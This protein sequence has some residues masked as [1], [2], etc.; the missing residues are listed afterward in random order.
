MTGP[1]PEPPAGTAVGPLAQEAAL[2]L[3]V[4]AD[5]LEQL[6]ARPDTGTVETPSTGTS[7]GSEP[8]GSEPTGSEPTG[9]EP[10]GSEPT[11][12]EPTSGEP[13]P[14]ASAAG[15]E[16]A[17][18]KGSVTPDPGGRCP[19][20]GSVPGAYCTACPLCR[21]MA[22]LRG[23]RPEATARLVDG[24]LLIVRTLRSLVPEQGDPSAAHQHPHSHGQ[25]PHS[26]AQPRPGGHPYPPPQSPSARR[27]GLEHINI[28]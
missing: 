28:L 15:Q 16:A 27:T 23:E 9:S 19:E 5:R 2:L 26:P 10:T 18:E 7:T 11:G 22:L 25:Q 8:T 17:E 13:G 24:A 6:K 3:D 20:C 14:A 1:R 4:V 12:S 21:F